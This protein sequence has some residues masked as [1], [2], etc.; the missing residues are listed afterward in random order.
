M[1]EVYA[2]NSEMCANMHATKEKEK[3]KVLPQAMA[4]HGYSEEII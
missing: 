1:R 4:H 2:L 3:T